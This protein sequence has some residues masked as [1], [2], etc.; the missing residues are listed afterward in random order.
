M[1]SGLFHMLFPQLQCLSHLIPLTNPRDPLQPNSSVASPR[2]PTRIL[3]GQNRPPCPSPCYSR[4]LYG[5][6]QKESEWGEPGTGRGVW[7]TSSG[8]SRHILP[9]SPWVPFPASASLPVKKRDL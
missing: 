8:P 5:L 1:K 2:K 3:H 7:E 6:F 4:T 9:L